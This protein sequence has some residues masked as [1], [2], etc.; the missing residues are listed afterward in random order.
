M[1]KPTFDPGLTTQYSGPLRRVINHDGTF[2]VIRRGTDWRDINPYLYL[3]SMPWAPFFS[4]VLI[5]YAFV[6]SLF[7]LLYYSL[8]PGALAGSAK[9]AHQ[10]DRFMQCFYFSSQTL[11]TVGFGAIAPSSGSA[12]VVS[13]LES[14]CGVLGFAVVTGLLYGRVSRP[15][16]RIG[17]SR[18]ALIAPYQDGTSL[19]FRMAN[20]RANTL[21]EPEATVMMMTVTLRDGV[22]R[23]DFNVLNLERAKIMMFPMTWT[24][25]HPIDSE[26]P[27][28]GKTAQDLEALQAEFMVSIK[29]WDETFSQTV[30]QRFSYRYNELVW[31]VKFTPA[32]DVDQNGTVQV[33]VDKISRYAEPKPALPSPDA[34]RV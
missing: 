15:S 9:A 16:A 14:L 1:Q 18:N 27:L 4:L 24:V 25:V 23:R 6:N 21:L 26:S 2:N 20:R 13:A 32:F 3:V 33:H 34:E 28:F 17:F 31:G 29:A 8:G 30:N 19:Q 22:H 11:T 10:I 12:N 7:A 5:G